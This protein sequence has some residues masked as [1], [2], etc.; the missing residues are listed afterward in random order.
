MINKLLLFGSLL[1][2]TAAYADDD[3][4]TEATINKVPESDVSPS[5]KR[6][7]NELAE[8]PGA[9]SVIGAEQ[10]DDSRATTVKDILDYTP[11]VSDEPRDGA[12]ADRLSIRGSGIARSFQGRGILLLQ[13]G[14]PINTADGS[15]D[16]QQIDPW[17]YKYT[18]V[19]LGANALQFGASDLGGAINFVTPTGYDN[20]AAS[21]RGE[22]GSF[23][24][25]HTE[26]S[27]AM[28]IGD[29]DY[30][31]QLTDFNEDG[32]R[33]QDDQ[34]S[35]R[36]IGNLGWQLNSETET[37]IY[38]NYINSDAQIPGTLTEAQLFGDPRQG[39]TIN[40]ASNYERNLE[41]STIADETAWNDGNQHFT[42]TVYY[43]YRNLVN[44]STVYIESGDNE[45]GLRTNYTQDIGLSKFIVGAN[46]YY[47]SVDE[48]RYGNVGGATGEKIVSRDENALT[49]ESYAEY[50]YAF[51]EE[52][53]LIG[54]TQVSYAERDIDQ[55]FP[56]NQSRDYDYT[57][58]NPRIGLRYDYD[59]YLQLF[60][61]LS[62]SFEPPTFFELSGGNAPGFNN[63]DAQTATT[64]EIGTRGKYNDVNFSFAYFNSW[65][66][67]ELVTYQFGNGATQT[68]NADKTMHQGI[69]IGEE[70][71]L[72]H[73]ITINEDVL[74][75]KTAYTYDDFR[76]N[77]D[78]QYGNN[79]EP[80][81]PE[82]FIR[83]QLLYQ[84]PTG[85]SFGPDLEWVPESYPI[86][87]A[88]TLFTKPYAIMG[89]TIGFNPPDEIY[90]FY[91]NGQNLFDKTYIASVGVIPN[92]GGND[93]SQFYPGNGRAIYSGFRINL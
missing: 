54:N 61:N 45:T 2:S 21:I 62:R 27:S 68:I 33:Q 23:G 26:L 76:L 58:F 70:I 31:A 37:R 46:L 5:E 44:P 24:E 57:G 86:D 55:Q 72:F 13:D 28:R 12:E 90:S 15:F 35:R 25:D 64:A 30:S 92:A 51:S 69:E 29:Y 63:L 52:W 11:G 38:V 89:F 22:I 40:I 3:V 48:D 80:G 19:F 78:P 73:D 42:S 65:L 10:Y 9:A 50:D 79:R 60:T 47:G 43:S 14:I 88:N 16:F 74:K 17:L 32:Y 66:N 7:E 4:R 49:A 91:I 34:N 77:D 53:H 85:L 56:D 75:L 18:E 83:S 59:P 82:H 41:I 87:M 36:F 20:Q 1:L 81:A 67:N 84:H 71:N 6:A 8:I 93:A 39:K